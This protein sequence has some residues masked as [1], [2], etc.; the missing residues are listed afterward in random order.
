MSN[1]GPR[2]TK[3]DLREVSEPPEPPTGDAKRLYLMGGSLKA[4]DE[5]GTITTIGAPE[6]PPED[7]YRPG[8]ADVAVADGG[9]GASNAAG[10][11]ANLG[12]EAAGTAAAAVDAHEEADDPHPQYLTASTPI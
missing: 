4:I 11:R 9:T 2:R 8:G 1:P 3:L 10:A 6:D 12:A 7:A 5:E